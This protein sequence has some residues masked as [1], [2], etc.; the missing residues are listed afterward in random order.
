[1][2]TNTST[3]FTYLTMFIT[4]I[5]TGETSIIGM[6][7]NILLKWIPYLCYKSVSITKNVYIFI[8]PFNI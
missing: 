7:N 5:F 3:N 6:K 2:K 1:M 8:P 4:N